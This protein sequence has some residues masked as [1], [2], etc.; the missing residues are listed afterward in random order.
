MLYYDCPINIVK[1]QLG[2][3]MANVKFTSI[4]TQIQAAFV[5]STNP[6]EDPNKIHVER[7]SK[8]LLNGDQ[9]K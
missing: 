1:N 8:L 2:K 9:K 5:T 3:D 4:I 7:T 6:V